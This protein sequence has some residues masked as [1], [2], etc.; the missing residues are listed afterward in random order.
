VGEA[1]LPEGFP[2]W[3]PVGEIQ[4]QRYPAYRMARTQS[5]GAGSMGA[6]WR[7]LSHIQGEQIA[8]TAPVEST[9]TTGT[10]ALSMSN[11]AFLYG[12]S[13]M[14]QPGSDG[15]VDVVDIPAQA[16]V[17]VGMRGIESPQRIEAARQQLERWLGAQ[18]DWVA[19]GSLRTMGYNSPRVMG[20]QR[21][22]EV[23][24]PVQSSSE[25][26]IDF[27]A[28]EESARWR[29]IDDAVMGGRSSSSVR[30]TG[31]ESCVFGGRLS[32]ENNGGFASVRRELEPGSLSDASMVVLRVRGD[33]KTYR[34]RFRT[35]SGFNVPSYQAEFATVA[36]EW[37]DVELALADFQ[38]RWRGRLVR[39]A[40]TLA[41]AEVRGIGLQ[42]ADEQVGAFSL[43]L[44]SLSAR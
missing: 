8:M 9:Y 23:Q 2:D 10:R 41:A 7:L 38:P 18:P 11:M 35:R 22:F 16:V 14:G 20:E 1:A 44:A 42:I 21:Y 13:R 4:I 29:A 27:A 25:R 40:A 19:A 30:A 43:E 5:G 31:D 37:I 6:F 34:L 17:S 3:T 26:V 32:L 39:S 24:I 33:G 15:S 28:A 36:G 12:S